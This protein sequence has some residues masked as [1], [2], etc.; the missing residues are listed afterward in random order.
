MYLYPYLSIFLIIFS[1]TFIQAYG[2]KSEF[3]ISLDIFTILILAIFFC[4]RGFCSTDWYNYYPVYDRVQEW[5]LFDYEYL[6]SFKWELGSM[7]FLV[8]MKRIGLDFFG[9][10]LVS[11]VIDLVI[12]N[13]FFKR[14]SD[15][16]CLS[17]IMFILFSGIMIEFN[18]LRNSK[19]MDCFL[20][21]LKY[22]DKS[23]IK[24]FLINIL[25]CFFH[26][27]AIFYILFYFVYKSNFFR[28]KKLVLILWI[29]GM[30]IY[31]TKFPFIAS[32]VLAI[33]D[34]LP[35]RLGYLAKRYT[36]FNTILASYGFGFGFIERF[37][38]FFIIYINQDKLLDNEKTKVFVP[39]IYLYFFFFLY[40]AEIFELAARMTTLSIV[41]YW[42][43][44]PSLVEMLS[45][46][47][48]LYFY[49]IFAFYAF[50]KLF[51]IY[52][53]DETFEYEN[54]LFVTPKTYNQRYIENFKSYQDSVL[55]N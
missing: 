54:W 14:Y 20:I 9:Y 32:F 21:S 48:K 16:R 50:I 25:G 29:F 31:V 19:A 45:K 28:K 24:Y 36:Y 43:L 38:T 15:N 53:H 39:L 33:S 1:F 27:T 30:V 35:G 17:W 46:K 3:T 6:K 52:A 23:K 41:A 34:S 40:L 47:R 12:I 2:H 42:I 22:I 11:A 5:R 49:V 26:I 10:C 18:L 55:G 4:F 8:L 7:F 44:I 51:A 37:I 13:S